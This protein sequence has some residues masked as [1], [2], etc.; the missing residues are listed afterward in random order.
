MISWAERV[1]TQVVRL[2]AVIALALVAAACTRAAEPIPDHASPADTHH[3]PAKVAVG[4]AVPTTTPAPTT[5]PIPTRAPVPEVDLDAF[6][7]PH[8]VERAWLRKD[9]ALVARFAAL[10]P[11]RPLDETLLAFGEPC[12]AIDQGL[13]VEARTCLLPGG[14]TRCWLTLL[15]HQGAVFD[16]EAQCV[17]SERSWTAI[18]PV[19]SKLYTDSLV[20]KG[21]S[22]DRNTASLST[23]DEVARERAVEAIATT[24]GPRSNADIPADLMQAIAT[25]DSPELTLTIGRAC[26]AAGSPPEGNRAMQKLVAAGREDLL[27][28][29][30]RGMN[31]G[32]RLYGY[33]GLRLLERN[34]PTDDATFDRLVALDLDVDTCGGCRTTKQKADTI[35]VAMFRLR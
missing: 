5:A 31:A 14:Y 13:G 21:F 15:S 3:E 23:R 28:N 32:G 33:I 7:L 16:A 25:L 26:G 22:I 17:A 2:A 29:V 18:A 30:M 34:T 9:V 12:T 4:P 6:D 11:L 1:S 19:I 20:P 24:L 8:D 27:R 10:L 35:D